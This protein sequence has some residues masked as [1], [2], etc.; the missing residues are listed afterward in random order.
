MHLAQLWLW[1][2]VRLQQ[3]WRNE[4]Q[5]RRWRHPG[6]KPFTSSTMKSGRCPANPISRPEQDGVKQGNTGSGQKCSQETPLSRMCSGEKGSDPE[7]HKW[8]LEDLV[9]ARG[10]RTRMDDMGSDSHSALQQLLL[11]TL[12][13]IYKW[14]RINTV[15][16]WS[17]SFS[18]NNMHCLCNM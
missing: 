2:D 14:S 10:G 9:A 3:L 4:R 11:R 17:I 16:N 7:W 6:E 5:R 8:R 1:Q 18:S 12:R 13:V 15:D